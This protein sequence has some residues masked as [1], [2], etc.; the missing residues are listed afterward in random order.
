MLVTDVFK[1]LPGEELWE[2]YKEKAD[3]PA[4]LMLPYSC[5]CPS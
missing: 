5:Q 4:K 2:V 3:E 1:R